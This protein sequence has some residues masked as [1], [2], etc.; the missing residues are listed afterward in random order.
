MI[1]KKVNTVIIF[2]LMIGM[3]VGCTLLQKSPASDSQAPYETVAYLLAKGT[4]DAAAAATQQA[5]DASMI[6]ELTT[7]QSATSAIKSLDEMASTSQLTSDAA[8]TITAQSPTP[9]ASSTPTLTSTP[10]RTSQSDVYSSPFPTNTYTPTITPTPTITTT[11]TQTATNAITATSTT[12]PTALTCDHGNGQYIAWNL[13]TG[14]NIDGDIHYWTSPMYGVSLLIFGD[15]DWAGS[16]DLSGNFQV[17]W[18]ADS[19]FVAVKVQDERYTQMIDNGYDI[20]LGDSLEIVFDANL[21]GD[22]NDSSMSSDDY[23]IGINPGYLSVNGDKYAF[24][25]FPRPSGRMNEVTVGTTRHAD[26][27]TIYEFGIPWSA[28][29]VSNASA[30]QAYGFAVSISDNDST[31][32]NEQETMLSSVYR[33]FNPKSWAA[34][35]LK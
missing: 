25:W 33:T 35:I 23:Q 8:A 17:G 21:C 15:K 3:M 7:P 31:S 30:G 13:G 27:S 2:L 9:S 32:A 26:D 20:Y 19:L 28:L 1:N 24:R 16:Y 6:A 22:F 18:N 29:G 11:T 34:V 4:Y 14:P 12:V 5:V 10:T